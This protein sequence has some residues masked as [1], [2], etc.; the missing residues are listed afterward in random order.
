VGSDAGVDLVFKHKSGQTW[1]V[2]AKCYAPAYDITKQDV[3]KFLSETNRVGI[4]HRLLITTTDRMGANARQ[5]LRAQEKPVV[6]ICEHSLKLLRSTTLITS[7]SWQRASGKSHT[8]RDHIKK[9]PS[10]MS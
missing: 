2:Q 3:D 4:D 6:T 5:V 7:A 1:A 9:K 10:I 8:I